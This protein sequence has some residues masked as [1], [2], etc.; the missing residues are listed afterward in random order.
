MIID[1]KL[2]ISKKKKIDLIAE[3]KQKGFK[4]IPKV[5]QAQKN[6]EMAPLVEDEEESEEDVEI[7][8]NAYD[9]LL[10]VSFSCFR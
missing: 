3:L 2:V 9:Y 7:G 1:G 8:S 6:G 5:A 4:P 10:S